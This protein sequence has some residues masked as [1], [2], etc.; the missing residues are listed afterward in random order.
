MKRT[1][2]PLQIC[3]LSLGCPKNL[4]DSEVIAGRLAD[5]GLEIIRDPEEADAVVINTCGFVESARRE[6]LETIDEVCRLKSS[7]VIS[8]VVVVGCLVQRYRKALLKEIPEVDAFLPITDYSGLPGI[9][10]ALFDESPGASTVRGLGGGRRTPETDLCR[11]LLTRP[12]TSYLRVAE[13]CNHRCSFCA[14]PSIRG[15]LRSKPVETLVREAQ[16]LADAGV[17]EINLVAEDTTD[18]G[19]DLEGKAL[20][21]R[22]RLPGL[23]RRLARVDGLRW[24]RI[25]YAY[26]SRV[27]DDLIAEMARNPKVLPYIDMPIQHIS[28]RIL[29]SMRRGT[30]PGRIRERID[31]L[32]ARIPGVVLRTR[33]IVGYPGESEA[34]FLELLD[35]LEEIRFER[36]GAFPFSPEEDT[37]AGT[38]PKR[39]P[40]TVIR[41]RLDRVMTLER[42]IIRRRNKSLVGGL[43]EV[44]VDVVGSDNQA[45]GRTRADAPDIDCGVMLKASRGLEAGGLIQARITGFSGYDL[46]AVPVT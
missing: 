31:R 42:R 15:R 23:L 8:A 12:H 6:S 16:A 34:E 28:E 35:F 24:I 11:L 3:L 5:E 27:T 37:P 44:I 39:V 33:V 41:E 18:Y 7:G 38:L 13:G 29:K 9:L 2:P 1:D 10:R 36:L 20:L 32:R 21:P 45:Y 4:V 30:P 17:K 22:L 14:I 40:D 19:R 46:L 25:L 43:E 26:P